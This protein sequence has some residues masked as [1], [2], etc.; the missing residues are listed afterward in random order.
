MVLAAH[1]RVDLR[2]RWSPAAGRG[3]E[4]VV[5]V[6]VVDPAL[7]IMQVADER[8]EETVWAIA[9]FLAT[10]RLLPDR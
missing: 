9:P 7:A 6:T 1:A 4:K 2:Q 3:G 8:G 10:H 5:R